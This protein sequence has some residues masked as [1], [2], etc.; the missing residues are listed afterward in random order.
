M[1]FLKFG[2]GAL[3]VALTGFVLGFLLAGAVFISLWWGFPGEWQPLQGLPEA[4][5]QILALNAEEAVYLLRT[6]DGKLYTCHDQ[7]CSPERTDWSTPDTRCDATNRPA[8]AR[9]L[10]IFAARGMRGVLA[11]ER[12]Y[13]DIARTVYV[14]ELA[15]KGNY[16]SSGVSLIP[17]DAGVIGV[18][19]LGG[20]A[21]L[22]FA[23]LAGGI[24][25]LA[26][27]SRKK[28]QTGSSEVGRQ[29]GGLN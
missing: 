8:T 24:A 28:G 1:K 2:C 6:T 18:G 5:Q 21:G 17:T 11:C 10:P 27:R 20:L 19:L 29:G 16:M 26:R 7:T 15:G 23:L 22:V 14:V 3:L 12:A 4:A 13:T 9:L 25:L